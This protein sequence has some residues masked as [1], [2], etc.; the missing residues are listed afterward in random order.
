MAGSTRHRQEPHTVGARDDVWREGLYTRCYM[1]RATAA[2]CARACC[3]ARRATA[4]AAAVHH[5]PRARERSP[6]AAA[7]GSALQLQLQLGARGGPV[8]WAWSQAW[9]W[10]AI[11][12]AGRRGHLHPR[13]RC[14]LQRRRSTRPPRKQRPGLRACRPERTAQVAPT[15]ARGG[16]HDT[17]RLPLTA[18]SRLAHAG[19]HGAGDSCRR[20]Q[21]V[22][23]QGWLDMDCCQPGGHGHTRRA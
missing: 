4:A 15:R 14:R 3:G 23:W 11:A 9:A 12:P 10:S 2:P 22:L 1:R 6:C 8:P 17:R 19:A 16:E 13:S 5:A 18:L 7:P 21:A 20:Q